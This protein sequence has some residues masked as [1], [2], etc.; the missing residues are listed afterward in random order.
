MTLLLIY[1]SF[2]IS[3]FAS[4]KAYG[5]QRTSAM[6]DRLEIGKVEIKVSFWQ[7]SSSQLVDQLFSHFSRICLA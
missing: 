7:E 6:E 4:A 2:K 3:Y 1:N 5:E